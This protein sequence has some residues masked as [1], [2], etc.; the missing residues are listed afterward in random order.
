MHRCNQ[1]KREVSAARESDGESSEKETVA[2]DVGPEATMKACV[3][4]EIMCMSLW[5]E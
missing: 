2:E 1:E 4:D 5:E 3:C